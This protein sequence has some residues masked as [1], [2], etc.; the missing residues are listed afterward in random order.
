MSD[1]TIE[2]LAWDPADHTELPGFAHGLTRYGSHWMDIGVS[3]IPVDVDPIDA[4]DKLF[5]HLRET[6]E[7]HV[8]EPEYF[9]VEVRVVSKSPLQRP[10]APGAADQPS[11]KGS[12]H[13]HAVDTTGSH[14]HRRA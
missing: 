2:V 1:K 4:L 6:I 9:S 10:D 5:A 11:K 7:Q 13:D 14:Q 12:A 3:V 8:P